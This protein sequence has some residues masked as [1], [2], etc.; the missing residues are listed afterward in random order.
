MV[1][2]IHIYIYLSSQVERKPFVT[3]MILKPVKK[4]GIE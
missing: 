3:G 2:G 1:Y 4:K